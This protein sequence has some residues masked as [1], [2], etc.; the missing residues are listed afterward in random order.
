MTRLCQY[1][2]LEKIRSIG[3]RMWLPWFNV[4]HAKHNISSQPKTLYDH[5]VRERFPSSNPRQ[6]SLRLHMNTVLYLHASTEPQIDLPLTKH[7][8]TTTAREDTSMK[9]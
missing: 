7:L 9:C 4:E 3:S 2:T 5:V 6:S 1:S 8:I